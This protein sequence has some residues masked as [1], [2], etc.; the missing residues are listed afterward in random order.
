MKEQKLKQKDYENYTLNH[1]MNAVAICSA[2]NEREMAFHYDTLS[3]KLISDIF[4]G[5]QD[6]V[7]S[8]LPENSKNIGFFH[9]HVGKDKTDSMLSDTDFGDIFFPDMKEL[10]FCNTD[11]MTFFILDLTKVNLFKLYKCVHKYLILLSDYNVMLNQYNSV[12]NLLQV[13]KKQKQVKVRFILSNAKK[14]MKK[15]LKDTFNCWNC[16]INEYN[17]STF[18]FDKK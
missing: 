7:T 12:K 13:I 10:S 9:T 17:I 4:I 14:R 15:Q 18:T 11:T 8:K 5:N 1:L 2:Q 16:M 6:G 3:R